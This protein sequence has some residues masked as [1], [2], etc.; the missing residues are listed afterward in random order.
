MRRASTCKSGAY[1]NV[2]STIA[3]HIIIMYAIKLRQPEQRHGVQPGE[4]EGHEK[5]HQKCRDCAM[6]DEQNTRDVKHTANTHNSTTCPR[7][8]NTASSSRAR[9]SATQTETYGRWMRRCPSTTVAAT[10]H[11]GQRSD[12]AATTHQ[13]TSTRAA[14]A[15]RCNNTSWKQC[16]IPHGNK[17]RG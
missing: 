11:V 2:Y 3:L 14:A 5:K 15:C 9:S 1:T 17:G 6:I 7:V 16:N 8:R 12:R 4:E 10:L 13:E